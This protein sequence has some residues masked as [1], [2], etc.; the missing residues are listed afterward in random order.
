[1][2]KDWKWQLPAFK[3]FSTPTVNKCICIIQNTY[4]LPR[5]L[6]INNYS[7]M[8]VT[9]GISCEIL[10]SCV[11]WVDH[12]KTL[13]RSK[14]ALLTLTTPHLCFHHDLFGC[15]QAAP[16]SLALQGQCWGCHSQLSFVVVNTCDG[17]CWPFLYAAGALPEM[18]GV[19]CSG[20]SVV[21]AIV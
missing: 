10:K 20:G 18:A 19:R 2:I 5:E 16:H 6:I 17:G 14:R 3:R 9:I 11:Y 7:L 13:W 4:H 8:L 21:I 15:L 12:L 1:M